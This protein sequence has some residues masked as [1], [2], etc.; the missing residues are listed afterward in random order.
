MSEPIAYFIF[1]VESIADGPLIESVRYSGEELSADEAIAKYQN[2]RFEQTGSTFIPHTFMLPIAVV[3]AKVT[4][5][6][7]LIDIVS[8]D[9][10]NFRP[11][12]ITKHFWQG[13]EAYQMPQ[14]VTFNGR[15]FDIPLMELSAFRCGLS[16]PKWFQDTGY[17]SP[18]SRFGGNSHLDLQELLTNYGAA[19]FNGGLNVAAQMLG[20]PG[21]M[22]LSGDQV[23]SYY[24]RGELQAI[25][26]YCRCDVLDTYFVFLR[27]MVLTGKINLEQE[28]ELVAQ[29][30]QW[31]ERQ[32]ETCG[33]CSA[34]LE[35]WKDWTN[36][37]DPPTPITDDGATAVLTDDDV[38][39]PAAN[40]AE[41]TTG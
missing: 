17:K 23:Q 11:H 35:K 21:K 36:P 34:Y 31:I 33:A 26:D 15:S 13:W 30:K 41:D 20:K 37:W 18:R 1:D 24:D 2:E 4:E 3:I 7:R 14:W 8:L 25:S 16:V 5:D 10:P 27:C 39:A 40:A 6:F 9:E 19:R 29:A 12:V 28:T 32:S 22:G 38:P